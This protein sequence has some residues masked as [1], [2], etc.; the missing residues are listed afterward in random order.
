MT[1]GSTN[2]KDFKVIFTGNVTS[3]SSIKSFKW[4]SEC[5]TSAI[6]GGSLKEQI[7]TTT[8]A[9]KTNH[10]NNVEAV[11]Q[12]VN[13]VK[14]AAKNTA[15]DVKNQIQK[16]KDSIQEL[17]NLFKKPA[18]TESPDVAPAAVSE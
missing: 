2:A 1:S 12:S 14:E 6:T 10:Q 8:E 5:D 18:A 11:K 4:L 7:K 17:K 3:A 13:D 16:T 9:L 15:E